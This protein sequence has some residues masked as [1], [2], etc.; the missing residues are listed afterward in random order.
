MERRWTGGIRA[1]AK[2]YCRYWAETS[3]YEMFGSV[4]VLLEEIWDE[5][6]WWGTVIDRKTW[7][8]LFG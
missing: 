8:F 2:E 6:K 5:D 1:F 3:R 4:P 7:Q